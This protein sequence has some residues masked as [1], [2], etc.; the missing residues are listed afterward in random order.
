MR[1]LPAAPIVRVHPAAPTSDDAFTGGIE[2]EKG[3]RYDVHIIQIHL[4][5]IVNP[6]L[7]VI[8]LHCSRQ[9]AA[10]GS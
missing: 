9:S 4:L 10:V 7:F 6:F 2:L 1:V 8:A 5:Y 3:L